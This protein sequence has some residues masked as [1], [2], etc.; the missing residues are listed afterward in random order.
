V[1]DA[2]DTTKFESF[3]WNSPIILE[4]DNSDFRV[5]PK[6]H[7]ILR[8]KVPKYASAFTIDFLSYTNTLDPLTLEDS[9][10]FE[11]ECIL[12]NLNK[13]FIKNSFSL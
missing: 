12:Y 9:K 10:C 3:T 5:N 13:K 8:G 1:A 2:N 7:F 11:A 6:Q 4:L